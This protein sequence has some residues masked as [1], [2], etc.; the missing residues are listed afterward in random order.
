MNC[1]RS[2]YFYLV[3][4]IATVFMHLCIYVH[5]WYQ[6]VSSNDKYK[7]FI[8]SYLIQEVFVNMYNFFASR[9][10]HTVTQV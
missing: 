7:S 5:I 6:R 3:L 2:R 1:I 9:N 10:K 8:W 4:T